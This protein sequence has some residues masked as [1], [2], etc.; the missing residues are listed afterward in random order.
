MRLFAV[1]ALAALTLAVAGQAAASTPFNGLTINGVAIGGGLYNVTLED[2]SFDA[3]FPT[4]DLTFVTFADAQA[5]ASA[6]AARSEFQALVTPSFGGVLVPFSSNGLEALVAVDGG[7][8][9][10]SFAYPILQSHDYTDTGFLTW[11]TFEAAGVPEPAAW[12][13][14]LF[15]FATVG[16][17]LRRRVAFEGA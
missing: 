1:G 17:S 4:Q 3:V 10:P 12:A 2:G 13:L 8:L 7:T 11:A 5:A 15:G 16:A 6:V 9:S 14:M